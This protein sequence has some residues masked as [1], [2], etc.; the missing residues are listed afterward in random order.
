MMCTSRS[1]P[2]RFRLKDLEDLQ[3]PRPGAGT[4]YRKDELA[5]TGY[6]V[7]V[8]FMQQIADGT[9]RQA[10]HTHQ[11]MGDAARVYLNGFRS[12]NNTANQ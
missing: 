8:N 11:P 3:P 7:G 9:Y 4:R 12:W 5:T 10:N 2:L 1:G 6:N